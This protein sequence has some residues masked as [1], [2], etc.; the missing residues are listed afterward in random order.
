[1]SSTVVVREWR[2]RRMVV[3]L[4][5]VDATTGGS[6][7]QPL[8]LQTP[9]QT[10]NSRPLS[11]F[12]RNLSGHY[13]LMEAAGFEDYSE[14]F[15]L[16]ELAAAPATQTLTLEVSDPSGQ[17]LPRQ[18]SLSLP[19]NPAI[20]P[21]SVAA[22][23]SL[24]QPVRVALYPSPNA[25]VN[26]GWAVLRATV[27]TAITHQRLPWAV[28][29]AT[30]TETTTLTQAD[31]RGEALIAVP[32]IPIT[33][34]ATGAGAGP[35]PPPVTATEVDATLEVVFDPALTTISESADFSQLIDPNPNFRPDP[36]RLN[37]QR[38]GLLVGSVSLRLASGR[39]LP[40]RLAVTLSAVP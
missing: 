38:S 17:Y 11:R 1:M 21:A 13:V 24:F 37:T 20:D 8:Q 35:G 9:L 39:D 4:R 29:R 7:R 2:D 10:P 26:P 36:D 34:W 31:W 27:V 5:F 18:F 12:V 33:T 19:R 14:T 16:D 23:T 30:T 6:V 32:G 25:R 40:Y 3:A 15:D 22:A 28:V